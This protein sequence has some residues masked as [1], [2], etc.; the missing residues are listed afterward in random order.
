MFRTK[1][2]ETEKKN[3]H[4]SWL[5]GSIHDGYFI[6]VTQITTPLKPLPMKR[7][8]KSHPVWRQSDLHAYIQQ[9]QASPCRHVE[10]HE[11]WLGHFSKILQ[12]FRQQYTYIYLAGKMTDN[13][14]PNCSVQIEIR[15]LHLLATKSV[16]ANPF[17]SPMMTAHHPPSETDSRKSTQPHFVW[18]S[19]CRNVRIPQDMF[20]YLYP[21]YQNLSPASKIFSPFF[22]QM[23]GHNSKKPQLYEHYWGPF[24]LLSS[25]S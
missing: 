20:N 22:R 15:I 8:G 17:R 3:V 24:P 25:Q 7:C 1:H 4:E 19:M 2:L 12:F 11:K 13:F 16:D 6:E 5:V 23:F 18:K 21:G 10:I 14:N 9:A